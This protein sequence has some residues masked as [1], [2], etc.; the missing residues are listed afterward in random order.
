MAREVL[1][2][3][4]WLPDQPTLSNPGLTVA[5]GVYAIQTGYKPVGRFAPAENGQLPAACLG[6]FAC[7]SLD[8]EV[9]TVA[10]TTTNLYRYSPAGWTSVGSGYSGNFDWRFIQWGDLIIA[11]NGAD[12]PQ[13]LDMS[14]VSPTFSNLTGSPPVAELIT[15]VRDFVLLGRTGA[16]PRQLQWSGINREDQWTPGVNQGDTQLMPVGGE[17]IAI[18]GGEFGII[19]QEARVVR[20]TY[21]GPSAIFQFD[22]IADNIGCMVRGSVCR[23]GAVTYFLSTR[24]FARTDGAAVSLIGDEKVNRYVLSVIDRG[25]YNGMSVTVDPRNNLILWALPNATPSSIVLIYNYALDRWTTITQPVQRLFSGLTEGVTLE[26]LSALY[27]VLED[28]PASLD[29]T[30]WRGAEPLALLVNDERRLGS[31]GGL[32]RAAQFVTGDVPLAGGRMARL[33][34]VRLLADTASGVSVTVS[35]AQRR[36]DAVTSRTFTGIN[37][38]GDIPVRAAWR[39]P[40]M[41]FEIASGTPWTEATGFEVEYEGAGM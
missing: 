11:V 39:F 7:R 32:P 10:G 30:L 34:R 29:D 4:E 2:L 12:T 27:P 41:Q 3:G 25:S 15:S 16:N 23:V 38:F 17:I 5:D 6:A 14:A 36:G 8:G 19:L 21:V 26:Q 13:V 1:P 33:R 20:M 18:T 28:V 9:F 31:L 40:K 22:E 37:R 35:G 24:G